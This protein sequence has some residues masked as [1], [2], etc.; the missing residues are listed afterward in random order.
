M[1]MG[2]SNP[3]KLGLSCF[4][5]LLFLGFNETKMEE[6]H[7]FFECLRNLC[8]IE[9]RNASKKVGRLKIEVAQEI[10]DPQKFMVGILNI[11]QTFPKLVR[12]F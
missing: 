9:G 6:K 11:I 8:E 10:T 2:P 4:T 3:P 7:V 1:L 5:N 12:K